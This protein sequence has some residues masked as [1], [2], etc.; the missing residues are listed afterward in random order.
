MSRSV[1]Y[2]I[3]HKNLANFIFINSN[4]Y[5]DSTNSIKY[6]VQQYNY[7]HKK[8]KELKKNIVK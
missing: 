1:K 2:T 3:G 6:T 7:F 4:S 8:L 5:I